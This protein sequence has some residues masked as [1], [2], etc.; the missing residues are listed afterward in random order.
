MKNETH[1][2]SWTATA[3]LTAV[4]IL[5]FMIM[6]FCAAGVYQTIWSIPGKNI[7]IAELTDER[8]VWHD[9]A[10]ELEAAVADYQA[11]MN[12]EELFLLVADSKEI[13]KLNKYLKKQI[14]NKAEFCL[15]DKP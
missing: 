8:D 14:A 3:L 13:I 1:S 7:K 9:R 15:G 2:Q 12:F 5:S 11:A 4:C 6:F 10:I